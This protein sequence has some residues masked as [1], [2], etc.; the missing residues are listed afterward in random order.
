[1]LWEQLGL[2]EM[3][4][5]VSLLERDSEGTCGS[6]AGFSTQVSETRLCRRESAMSSGMSSDSS[7]F[8]TDVS[9]MCKHRRTA[10]L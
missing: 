5:E 3:P 10:G 4:R 6:K 1:M 9:D 7:E 2:E 8:S